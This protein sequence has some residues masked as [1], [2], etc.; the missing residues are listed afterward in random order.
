M[1]FKCN[2]KMEDVEM[3][4]DMNWAILDENPSWV[5]EAHRKPAVALSRLLTRH[6]CLGSELYRTGITYFVFCATLVI[7]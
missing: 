3:S 7:L 5:P 1:A 2:F 6:V 4:K